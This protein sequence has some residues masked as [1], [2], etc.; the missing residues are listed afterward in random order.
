MAAS[1]GEEEGKIV[2]LVRYRTSPHRQRWEIEADESG[3]RISFSEPEGP[4]WSLEGEACAG[5]R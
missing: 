1:Y 2:L 3:L 4:S 5:G